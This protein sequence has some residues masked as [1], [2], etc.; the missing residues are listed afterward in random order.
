M[1]SLIKK[2]LILAFKINIFAVIYAI[3][4]STTGL[5]GNNLLIANFLYVLSI[6]MLTFII[7]IYTNGYDDKYKSQIVLNSFP[8]DRRNIVR[9]KYITL[10]IFILISSG[11][12]LA[13]TNILPI[14][15]TIDGGTGANIH[16]VIFASNILLLFYAI[17]YP[18]YFKV[19]EGL[20]SFN[21][22]LWIFMMMGP[23]LL[24]KLFK[25]LDK[26]GLLVKLMNVN[27][28]KINLYLLGITIVI[29]YVSLQISKKIY[30]KREF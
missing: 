13:F 25:F 20:R 2:D 5:I 15:F 14:I 4:I 17:Y 16:A 29:Y 8:I 23:A 21:T 7:V 28:D 18:F 24:G 19:G 26:K 6:I 9:S 10:I 27:L 11:A 30:M 1:I 12:I 22:V 3:F